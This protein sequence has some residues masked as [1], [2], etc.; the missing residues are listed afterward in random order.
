MTYD[1]FNQIL[2][3]YR[4]TQL[5]PPFASFSPDLEVQALSQF[6]GD[7]ITYTCFELRDDIRTALAYIQE[8]TKSI[9][10]ASKIT[11]EILMEIP[12]KRDEKLENLCLFA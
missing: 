11:G 12:V 1:Y 6:F 4:Y 3:T 10:I 2:Y 8:H 5:A 7:E 9:T